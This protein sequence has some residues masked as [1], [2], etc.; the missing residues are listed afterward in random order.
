MAGNEVNWNALETKDPLPKGK[1]Y[2]RILV[3]TIEYLVNHGCN[4]QE[5]WEKF[6]H[7]F[8]YLAGYQGFSNKQE[9]FVDETLKF[10]EARRIPRR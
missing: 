4:L 6:I 2:R 5:P 3:H 1:S 7:E 10:S 9:L 8:K